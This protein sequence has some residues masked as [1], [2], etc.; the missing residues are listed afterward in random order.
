MSMLNIGTSA[1]TTAQGALSTTS[2]N[3]S[4]V[5]TEGFNRQRVEQDTRIPN[6]E[7]GYYIGSG[8]EIS[9]VERLFDQFL[10]DQVRVFT[11]QQQQQD[12]FYTFARQVDDLLGSPELSLSSGLESFFD[13]VQEVANDPTSIPARQVMLTEADTLAKRFNTL[14]SQLDA[15]NDQVNLNLTSAVQNVNL[16]AQGISNLNAAIVEA[17]GNSG[18][19]PNDL[20]DQRDQLINKLSSYISVDT[21]EQDN[22]AISVFIGTG[23]GLVVGNSAIALKITTDPTD[24]TRNEIGYGPSNISISSQLTGGSIG[25]LLSVRQNVIDPARAEIDGL[26]AGLIATVN[27]QHSIGITLSGQAGGNFFEPSDPLAVPAPNAGSIRLAIVDPQDIAVAFP[28]TTTTSSSNSGTGVLEV[29]SVDGSDPAFNPLTTLA[30]PVTFSYNSSTGNYDLTYD[31]GTASISYNP[32][33]DSGKTIDLSTLIFS[34][35]AATAP[36]LTITLSGVPA[37]SDSFT[38]TNSASG[39]FK[40]VG[41]NRN[42]LALA[43][44]QI[45]KTLTAL[46]PITG[47]A[48]GG[49]PTRSFGD[50]YGILVANVATRTQQA[51][52]G[53]KTQQGL[54]DQTKLRYDSVSGVNLDEEAANLMK[55]QQ[56]YQAA[57]QIITVSNTVFNAL[58]NAI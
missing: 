44:L 49:T 10:A 39:G 7:G 47:L 57:S 6:F 31:G 45:S 16:L 2:H 42:A 9:T 54:L 22:G 17:K 58:I 23:Q 51:E 40:A 48:V 32:A 20:L 29:L 55:F 4:N 50:A 15:F 41:D 43:E 56:A 35:P 12:T 34:A 1:L 33:S 28:V 5:N 53:Q 14:D 38:L 52:V 19:P 37:D 30:T 24:T 3:I 27:E 8:V 26:A 18:A 46:D 25:G 13:S 11:S 21:I 36:P